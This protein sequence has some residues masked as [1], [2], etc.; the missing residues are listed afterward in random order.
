MYQPLESQL[1]RLVGEVPFAGFGVDRRSAHVVVVGS[2][3]LGMAE[4]AGTA[5]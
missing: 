5:R 2:V 1:S 3:E 4:S